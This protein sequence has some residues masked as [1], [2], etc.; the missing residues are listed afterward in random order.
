MDCTEL[1]SR[2]PPVP[3]QPPTDSDVVVVFDA[4]M[5]AHSNFL[6]HILPY[7]EEDPRTALVQTPQVGMR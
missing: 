5:K 2:P 4:D 3:V 7:L 1:P 6:H